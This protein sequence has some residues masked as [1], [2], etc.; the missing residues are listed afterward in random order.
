MVEWLLAAMPE[1]TCWEGGLWGIMATAGVVGIVVYAVAIPAVLF[2]RLRTESKDEGDDKFDADFM[3]S[4]GWLVLRYKP[5]RWWFEFPLSAYK[6]AVI[7]ASEL[8]NSDEMAFHLLLVLVTATALLLILV[9]RD[10]P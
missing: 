4:H 1:I 10:L 3:E 5:S 8:M 2:M 9:V 6:V 7:F